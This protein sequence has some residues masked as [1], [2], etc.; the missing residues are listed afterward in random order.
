MRPGDGHPTVD[1]NTGRFET[2]PA[3]VLSA[4]NLTIDGRN[5]AHIMTS[6]NMTNMSWT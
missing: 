6:P 1:L 4:S 3:Q 5:V 2:F